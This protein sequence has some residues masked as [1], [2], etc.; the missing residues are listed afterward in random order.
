V[1][2]LFFFFVDRLFFRRCWVV[3][4]GVNS[5]GGMEKLAEPRKGG[6][7]GTLHDGR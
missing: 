4:G 2:G 1:G 3:G 6:A 5:L 7:G